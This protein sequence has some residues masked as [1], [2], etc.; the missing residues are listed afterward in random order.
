MTGEFDFQGEALALFSRLHSKVFR[1]YIEEC[2]A[3]CLAWPDVNGVL[4]A[5]LA[6]YAGLFI[7]GLPPEQDKPAMVA[8]FAAMVA[9][10][11]ANQSAPR[12]APPGATVQ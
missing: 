11:V 7:A 1:A 6:R 5:V 8:R 3:R 9:D 2:Q 4:L 12:R 10:E